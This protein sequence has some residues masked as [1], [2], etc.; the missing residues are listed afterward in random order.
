MVALLVF[1]IALLI[2]VL[3]SDLANRSVLSTAV[4]FLF[5]GFVIGDGGL[6]LL[7]LVPE[8]PVVTKLAEL[9]LFSVLFTDGM[10]VG[11]RELFSCWHLPGRAL[12]IGLPL[13]LLVT[14]LLAHWIAGL[15]WLQAFIVGAVLSPTDPVFAAAIVGRKEVPARLRQLLNVES[16]LNDGLAL[17]VVVALL[18][19]LGKTPVDPGV[20]GLE[21][22]GGIVLGIVI[23]WIGARIETSR[24]FSVGEEYQPLYAFAIALL[25]YSIAALTH[26]NVYLAA[27]AAG[28]TTASVSSDLR[29][30]FHRFGEIVAEL[31]KLAALLVF[32]ALISARFFY[33]VGWAGWLFCFGALILPRAG[34]LMLS[35]VGSELSWKERVTASWFGPKGFAA[36]VYGLLVLQSGV[37]LGDRMFHLIALVIV[38]SIVTHSS[39]DVPLGRWFRERPAG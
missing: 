9:A 11:V 22:V 3:L 14:A 35:L 37:P 7:S 30:A 4:L 10:R 39:T 15:P 23:P 38:V 16:G 8:S 18:A 26:V 27:F 2:A 34:A 25:I 24:F 29:D 1:A 32:G 6:G 13:T 36:V 31:F 17:P 28:V 19:M 21:L 5:A 12:L 33:D 20:L